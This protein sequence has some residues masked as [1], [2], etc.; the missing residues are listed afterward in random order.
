MYFF[1]LNNRLHKKC[2]NRDKFK[3]K[4][5]VIF[6]YNIIA[7]FLQTPGNFSVGELSLNLK[8]LIQLFI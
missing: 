5:L 3:S 8:Q 1:P 7:N 6:A 4:I 2:R